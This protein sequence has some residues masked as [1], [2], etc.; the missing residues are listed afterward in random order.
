LAKVE[1]KI[2]LAQEGKFLAAAFHPE[3]TKDLRIHQYFLEMC[4]ER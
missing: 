3:L 1:E 4:E 2:V